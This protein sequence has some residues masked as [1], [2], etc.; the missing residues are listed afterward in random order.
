MNEEGWIYETNVRIGQVRTSIAAITKARKRPRDSISGSRQEVWTPTDKYICIRSGSCIY[1]SEHLILEAYRTNQLTEDCFFIF[2]NTDSA[3][4]RNT[5]IPLFEATYKCASGCYIKVQKCHLKQ[6]YVNSRRSDRTQ[7]WE[8]LADKTPY[9]VDRYAFRIQKQRE[10]KQ[11]YE[12][13]K[14]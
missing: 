6:A 12:K 1:N 7:M 4:E 8:M 14:N 5:A 10:A 3:L 13:N 9:W 2:R 11:R